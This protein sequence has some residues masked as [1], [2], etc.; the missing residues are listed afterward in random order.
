MTWVHDFLVKYPE[1][2]LFLTIGLGYWVGGFRFGHFKLGPVTGS[3]FAGLAIGQLAEVPVSGMAKSF[4]FLLFLFGI[5]YSVGP[6]FM[7]ALKRDGLKPVALG[8]VCAATGLATAV[9]L[10]KLLG[11][12]AGFAAGLLSGALTESPAMGTAIEAIGALP[13]SEAERAR[14]IAHVPV[15]D[16]VTYVFGAAGC[17]WF[18]STLAPKLLGIDLV[19][20]ARK[21]EAELGIDRAKPGVVSAW[22]PIELRAFRVP[23]GGRTVGLT[24]AAAE[25]LLPEYRMFVQRVR[26]DGVILDAAPDL[27]LQAGDIV[28]VS[29]RRETLVDVLGGMAQ[30]VEDR[31]LLDI[32]VL[33]AEVMVTN[34]DLAGR[35]LAEAAGQEWTRSLFLRGVTRGG[36]A[37]PI[38]PGLVLRRGDLAT[39]SGP[40]HVVARAAKG[41]GPVVAPTDET[42]FVALCL[43][44]FL[45]GLAGVLIA[46]PVG[47]MTI[48]LSTSVG[49]LLAGLVV[50]HTRTRLPLF[51]RIPDGAVNLMTALGL[52]AFVA[53]TGLHAGPVFFSALAEAGIGLFFAGIV[54]TM[55]PLVV[56]LYFGRH[57]LRMNPILL[58][59]GLAGAQTMT[60][61]MAAVQ[62]RSHSPVAVLGYT[63]VVPIAHILLTSW[64][65]VIVGIMAA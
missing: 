55:A 40:E 30:E 10:A 43:A 45:G 13:I 64:G 15:A 60:A 57:V 52:A 53:M 46:F 47:G 3:L 11:L 32:P 23:E 65:S 27:V 37:L 17:I 58:L 24:I 12:D 48:S 61:A 1:L 34:K 51:A 2:A 4:L 28:A 7:Q 25:A 21:L 54:V 42:D 20:E 29:G 18:L 9:T 31:E 8:V 19:E 33:V 39:V 14:L 26:R 62:E 16:A 38:G 44:I 6:Q 56:G 22:R 59:G 36:Q 50:G 63:P 41:I 35:T 49:T 5:G